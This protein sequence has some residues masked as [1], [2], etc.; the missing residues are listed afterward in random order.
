M[1]KA[2]IIAIGSE[3]LT[4]E[5][6]DTNSLFLTRELN[7]IGIVVSGKRIVGDTREE[8][9][10]AI[11]QC[12]SRADLVIV[13]GGLGP[14]EDDLTREGASIALG[15][16]LV[17]REEILEAIQDRFRRTGRPISERNRRQAYV[18]AN[19]WVLP[20]PNGTA[21]GQAI[22]LDNRK[23]VYLLPGPPRE[24]EPMVREQCVP[25]WKDFFPSRVLRSH[26]LR[27]A[28]MPESA[29]DELAAPVYTQFTNPE[30]TI[31]ASAGDITLQFRATADTDAEAEQLLA[32]VVDPIRELLGERIYSE[33]GSS[34]EETIGKLLLDRGETVTLA[35]SCT[36]GLVCHRIAS[37]PGVSSALMGGFVVYTDE[38]KAAL[39]G[40]D[41]QLIEKHTAVSAEVA[42]ALAVNTRQRTGATYAVSVTG[43]AGP[44]G[45]SE[46]NP[47]G[48]VYFGVA[49][50]ERCL[51]ERHVFVGDRPHVQ[52]LSSQWALDILRMEILRRAQAR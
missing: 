10:E 49:T 20:N 15:Q 18:L 28:R 33:D 17:F 37:V 22:P 51:T 31:L 46:E 21:P 47:V 40:V 8:I 48:T 50:P 12:L 41:E 16:E 7:Q 1:A 36:A 45:G 25:V 19:A 6:V 32:A 14:T 43:Y 13:S 2:Q 35:E 3:M 29:V 44:T 30:T 42:E 27:I 23:M 11:T 5:K 52:R 24:L 4:P 26:T 9:A 34:L 38:M 39:A